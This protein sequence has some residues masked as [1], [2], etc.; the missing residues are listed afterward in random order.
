M[1]NSTRHL[2]L[3]LTNAVI[4][5]MLVSITGCK[6][7]EPDTDYIARVNDSYLSREEFSSLVD[8]VTAGEDRKNELITKWIHRELLYQKALNEGIL[9]N[10][11]YDRIIQHSSRE[12]AG[13][14]LLQRIIDNENLIV[15]VN[16][17]KSYYE[18]NKNDFRSPFDSYI[19]NSA[20]FLDEDTAIQFRNIA[21]DIGWEKAVNQFSKNNNIIN[22][23]NN[24]LVSDFEINPA[25]LY[26]MVNDLYPLE[27]SIVISTRAGYYTVVQLIEK[28]SAGS[29]PSFEYVQKEAI[30]RVSAIKKQEIVNDYLK[31]LYASGKIEIKN[32]E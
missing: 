31:N 18:K 26:R 5:L 24:R 29:V 3:T 20:E 8:T 6:Q 32:Q 30:E 10:S 15:N 14:L 23:K 25:S 19:L 22:L 2:K 27:I 1:M 4:A 17:A 7:E 9:Q 11:E 28:L 13:A 16:E 21:V 12:L